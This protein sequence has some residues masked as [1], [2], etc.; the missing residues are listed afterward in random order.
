MEK[1][2]NSSIRIN[3]HNT[4]LTALTYQLAPVSKPPP[5]AVDVEELILG[6]AL[7]DNSAEAQV[8]IFN[9]LRV[10]DFYKEV[11]KIIYSNMLDMFR[12]SQAIDLVTITEKLASKGLLDEVGGAIHISKLTNRVAS[13]SNVETHVAIVRQK[14]IARQQIAFGYDLAR[15]AYDEN[16]VFE[17]N[18]F[19][20]L[21]INEIINQTQLGSEKVID[22][23]LETVMKNIEKAKETGGLTG[24][25]TGFT[26]LDQLHGGYKPGNLYIKAG[27]PG[28]G[29]TSETICEAVHQA[30]I[31]NKKVCFFSL[32]MPTEQIVQRVLSVITEIP[33]WKFKKGAFSAEDWNEFHS[34]AKMVAEGGLKFFDN[35]Y[36]IT[37]IIATCKKEKAVHGLDCVFID[38]LQII[39]G[40]DSKNGNREQE[41][42]GM[43]RALKLLSNDIDTPVVLLSQLNRAVE[44]RGGS[45]KPQLSDLR[46]SGAIEQDADVVE[47]IYRPEYYGIEESDSGKDTKGLAIVIVAKNRH[48]GLED[49]DLSFVKELTKFKNY[50]AFGVDDVTSKKPKPS[51]Q[52]ATAETGRIAPRNF[53]QKDEDLF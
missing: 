9:E 42:S 43:T 45:K 13:S 24:V 26:Q 33:L 14:S 36:R 7:I 4:K 31:L 17:N 11:N 53:Y 18:D 20:L 40:F 41:I 28:M 3:N 21:K 49:V 52:Q 15:L 2:E 8:S 46:E 29:K 38:Y 1:N 23:V 48:G 50:D 27:R 32:E 30:Y 39:Q 6:A 16:D 12:N 22:E 34:A 25:P 35:K 19:M 5:Q 10:D 47:F 37:D 51:P 44:T